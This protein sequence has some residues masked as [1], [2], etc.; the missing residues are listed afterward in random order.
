MRRK[1]T[2]RPRRTIARMNEYALAALVFGLGAGLK[3][4]PLASNLTA[5]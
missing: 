5:P 3:P 4:G 2:R 1:M